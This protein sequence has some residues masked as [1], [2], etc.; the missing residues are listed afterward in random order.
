MEVKVGDKI[1]R[2]TLVRSINEGYKI[3]IGIYE[4]VDIEVKECS[5]KKS[6]TYYKVKGLNGVR[7]IRIS[8][9]KMEKVTNKNTVFTTN[10]EVSYAQRMFVE[11]ERHQLELERERLTKREEMF[12]QFAGE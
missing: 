9:L 12:K 5:N 11:T 8:A 4:V 10:P 6:F 1:Y 2:W 7:D 3:R